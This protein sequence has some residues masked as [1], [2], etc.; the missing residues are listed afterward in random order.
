ML[1]GEFMVIGAVKGSGSFTDKESG[2]NI[3]WANTKIITIESNLGENST[4]FKTQEF[5]GHTELFDKVKVVPAV[6]ILSMEVAYGKTQ[7]VECEFVRDL[8]IE[9]KDIAK[10]VS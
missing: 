7:I 8:V 2:K 10:K 4:G 3:D 9:Q 5:K 6:Y 1:K